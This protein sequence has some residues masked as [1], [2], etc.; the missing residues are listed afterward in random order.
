MLLSLLKETV[1][2]AGHIPT[3][4]ADAVAV[5]AATSAY[6]IGSLPGLDIEDGL[7]RLMGSWDRYTEILAEFCSI[8]QNFRRETAFLIEKGDFESARMK[9]HSLKGAAGNVSAARLM[10]AAKSLEDAISNRKAKDIH[11]GLSAVDHALSE[12]C[13]SLEKISADQHPRPSAPLPHRRCRLHHRQQPHT[14]V[15]DQL[16]NTHGGAPFG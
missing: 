12:V 3:I 1:G 2:S 9:T 14:M 7:A 6:A 11:C 5:Q 15:P 13:K 8:H 16:I 10:G 4:S